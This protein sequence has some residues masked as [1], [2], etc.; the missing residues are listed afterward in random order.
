MEKG[1]LCSCLRNPREAIAECADKIS[2]EFFFIPSHQTLFVT[3]VD[4]WKAGIP[5]DLIGF[6]Q[7]L[8]DKNLLETVGGA[9]AVTEIYNFVPDAVNLPYY[10]ENLTDK[11]ILRSIIASAGESTRRCYE[12]Q[13]EA[14]E[15]LEQYQVNAIEIGHLGS[16]DKTSGPLSRFVP[17]ALEEIKWHY[18]NRGK[19]A[20][21]STGFVDLDRIMNGFEKGKRPYC[22]AARP[23]MGKSALLLDFAE[24]IAIEAAAHRK[25][26]KIFS[27]E[28]TGRSLAKRM[29]AKRAE[30]NLVDLRYGFTDRDGISRAEKAAQELMTD[31]IDIDE[32]G[33]LS[34][35]E[36]RSRARRAVV[37]GK[38]DI[39][40]VDYLQRMHG[41][42]KRSRENRQLEINEISQGISETAKEL[43]VPII[44]LAQLNRSPE[45]RKD[46]KPELG[47]L[48]ESGSIEQEMGLVGLLWRPSYY[49]PWGSAKGEMIAEQLRKQG[50]D[51]PAEEEGERI[52][53]QYA[54]CIIA[55]QNEGPDGTVPLR[56]VK[57]FARYESQDPNRPLF[58]NRA[59]QRQQ[60][61]SSD[62]EK[63]KSRAR[64]PLVQTA[65]DVFKGTIVDNGK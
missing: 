25:R 21:V 49:A 56:F 31:Y 60:V 61:E 13:A 30:L 50:I 1:A 23:A 39:I 16:E 12:E 40:M 42:T 45:E 7:T 53:S 55:K 54:E 46:G 8:R 27:V 19:C 35:V 2:E 41:S 17:D 58:S 62:G 29:I 11:Y 52:Y 26:V 14:K 48:R 43:N 38:Y 24:K 47:D 5:I 6:T 28:M 36:F 59:D 18:R 15:I 10:L 64:E 51:I 22:F 37:R 65:L 44:V 63:E 57:E 33:D 34:I 9:S 4:L 3:L 32:K 20:G